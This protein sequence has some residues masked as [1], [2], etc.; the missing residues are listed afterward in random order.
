MRKLW[1][2]FQAAII[3]LLLWWA[4]D[5]APPNGLSKERQIGFAL[6]FGVVLAYTFTWMLTAWI[7]LGSA[8]ARKLRRPAQRL[9]EGGAAGID[10]KVPPR[11]KLV[12]E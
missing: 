6:F 7:E 2:V 12:R 9:G 4:I 1:F 10:A 8:L 11:H 3:G 5:D